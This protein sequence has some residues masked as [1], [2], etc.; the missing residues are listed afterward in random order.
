MTRSALGWIIAGFLALGLG[1]TSIVLGLNLVPSLTDAQETGLL[2]PWILT[3]FLI[4]LAVISSMTIAG[5]LVVHSLTN[6]RR[7]N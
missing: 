3:W 2:A 4:A 5:F 1:A 7:S 6:E